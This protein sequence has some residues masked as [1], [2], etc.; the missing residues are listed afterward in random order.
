MLRIEEI[1]T[2][3][4]SGLAEKKARNRTGGP[5]RSSDSAIADPRE[6]DGNVL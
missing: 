3:V 5:N 1:E 2:L 6:A 4:D